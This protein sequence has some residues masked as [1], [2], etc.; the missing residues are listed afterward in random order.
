MLR[1]FWRNKD[2]IKIYIETN[3]H[4]FQQ[5]VCTLSDIHDSKLSHSREN[6]K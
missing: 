6:L 3:Q 2:I 5:C 1:V 4:I